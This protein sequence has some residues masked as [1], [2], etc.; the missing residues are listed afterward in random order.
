MS[1][2]ST[3]FNHLIEALSVVTVKGEE[4][5][6]EGH[7]YIFGYWKQCVLASP[8][9]SCQSGSGQSTERRRGPRKL[10]M[11]FGGGSG[12]KVLKAK[13]KSTIMILAYV[14]AE[15]RC[16]KTECSLVFTASSLISLLRKQAAGGPPLDHHWSYVVQ[17]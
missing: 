11:F 4:H 16:F 3:N 12:T 9:A 10:F 7:Q 1:V 15:S 5:T 2:L 6:S 13:Q 14:P 8:A 17:H